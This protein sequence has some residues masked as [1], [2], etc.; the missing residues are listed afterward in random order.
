MSG[1]PISRRRYLLGRVGFEVFRRGLGLGLGLA[2]LR[3]ARMREVSAFWRLLSDDWSQQIRDRE[4][5]CLRDE[6][7]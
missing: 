1:E 5:I 6:E 3:S 7:R 4:G 2:G